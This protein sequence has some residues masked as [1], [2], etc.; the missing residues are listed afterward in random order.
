M[1]ALRE[2]Q[3]RTIRLSLRRKIADSNA[4]NNA[5]EG[6]IT[7]YV[8]FCY[9]TSRWTRSGFGPMEE[10]VESG[11]P[12]IMVLWH[13]RLVMSPYLFDSSKGR[14][15]TLTS[16]ARAGRLAG[17]V[18]E[19]MGFDTIPM[20][21]RKRHVALSREVLRRIKGGSSVGIAADGPRGPA[22]VSTGVPVIWARSSGCRVFTISFAQRRTLRLPTWDKQM[23]PVPFSRGVLMCREWDESVPRKPTPEQ[24]EELRLSLET[25]LNQIT[26]DSDAAVGRG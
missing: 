17:K 9:R 15:C 11:E 22:R 26:D 13:Q 20:S 16:A 18:Q 8:K 10:L 2:G 4:F 24:T 5:V 1:R 12:V 7:G 19:R 14:I 3:K 21:S 23:L 6:L 25:A